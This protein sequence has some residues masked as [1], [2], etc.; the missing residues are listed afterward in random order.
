MLFENMIRG[1]AMLGISIGSGWDNWAAPTN[2]HG[3]VQIIG[4]HTQQLFVLS[5]NYFS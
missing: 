1:V 4:S 5:S 2:T 3:V